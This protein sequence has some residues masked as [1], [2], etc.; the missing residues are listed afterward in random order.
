MN[1]NEKMQFKYLAEKFWDDAARCTYDLSSDPADAERYIKNKR[2]YVDALVSD[3]ED[4]L[5]SFTP[6]GDETL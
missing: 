3:L 6:Q 2:E 5:A 1:V 4:T